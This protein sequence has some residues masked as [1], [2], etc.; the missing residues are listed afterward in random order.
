MFRLDFEAEN[1]AESPVVLF[2]YLLMS[3]SHKNKVKHSYLDCSTCPKLEL[4]N[5]NTY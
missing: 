4:F 2:L 3:A 1:G 5:H